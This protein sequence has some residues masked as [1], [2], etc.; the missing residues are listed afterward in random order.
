MIQTTTFVAPSYRCP[1]C[2]DH[3]DDV[4]LL[5]SLTDK[6]LCHACII[7][8]DLAAETGEISEE[9]RLEVE[10]VS[11]RPWPEARVS[12]LR[13]AL[14]FWEHVVARRPADYRSSAMRHGGWSAERAWLHAREQ[15]EEARNV[16]RKAEQAAG[17]TRPSNS[18]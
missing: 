15:L 6:P 3:V 9:Q 13:D 17:G 5:T 18:A 2:P 4:Y 7:E 11:G 12:L 8:L 14:D 16:L 10:R 1:F